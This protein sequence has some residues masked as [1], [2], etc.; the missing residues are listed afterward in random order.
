[1]RITD[2][3]GGEKQLVWDEKG[4]LVQHTDCSGKSTSYTWTPRGDLASIR[5]MQGE[6]TSFVYNSLHELQAIHHPDATQETFRYYPSGQL[7]Y[8]QNAAGQRREWRY[9]QRGQP[10]Q[11]V[12]RLSR[13]IQY[14]Y[15]ARGNLSRLLN[16]NGGEYRFRYDVSDRL[17]E[18]WRPDST[19]RRIEYDAA[20]RPASLEWLG[21]DYA[22][23]PTQRRTKT[24]EYDRGDRPLSCHTEMTTRFYTHDAAG[25]L[26]QLERRPTAAGEAQGIQHGVLQLKR[27]KNGRVLE[28]VLDG[29]TT[30]YRWGLLGE[31][32]ALTLPDNTTL[33]W[34][35]YGS[36]H[37]SAI[38]CDNEVVTEF[39]RDDLHREIRRSQGA[40]TQW[41]GYDARGRRHWQSACAGDMPDM[42]AARAQQGK[43]WRRF[44][45]DLAGEL[46]KTE[47]PFRGVQRYRY[48][49]ESRLLGYELPGPEGGEERFSY[50]RADNIF[51]L[52]EVEWDTHHNGRPE[53]FRSNRLPFWKGTGYRYDGFGNLTERTEGSGTQ[54]FRYDDENRLIKAWGEGPEG[55][56]RAEYRYDVL[57]R[58]TSKR[59]VYGDSAEAEETYFRWEGLRLV[60]ER[61]GGT[62]RSYV[63]D[64]D[65][66]Y[67]P[68]ARITREGGERETA[69]FHT[70]LNGTPLE[71]TD[72]EG[73]IRW[74][75][76]SRAWGRVIPH[77]RLEKECGG[78]AVQPLRYPGQYSDEETGLHYNTL[79]YYDPEVGR[80]TTQDP[81]GLAG[82]LNLYQYAPNSL[83]WIDPLGLKCT[84]SAKNPK[85]FHAAV[86]DKWGHKMTPTDMR[87]V[88]KTI[89]RIK[90]NNLFYSNDGTIFGNTHTIGNSNSQRL[91]T[92]SGPYRE[93]TVK[94]PNTGGN[95]ARRIVVDSATG[96]AYY[97]HDH[98]DS[99]IEISLGGWK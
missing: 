42:T 51:A 57:G 6:V 16:A 24:Y 79:R 58:R 92:G 62:T 59:V 95:G 60:Q 8:H 20:G 73:H 84:H 76:K 30:Q 26:V 56:Y 80:F 37:V 19:R 1:M 18:E 75:G 97:T 69:Y 93:W 48:D 68:L 61:R 50:D 13:T 63:Y 5:N 86:S 9:N 87:E 71:V 33:Q 81:I 82:G 53:G 2:A 10:L 3:G 46:V 45:F 72:G 40:L 31:L 49:A 36:G 74:C 94:T 41:R 91:N 83:S 85:E 98:Y 47:D 39:E 43:V 17:A 12:D 29:E 99:F 96:K 55:R 78:L 66:H 15:D 90:S 52:P 23:N 44:H 27:D 25:R 64:P 21:S 88:Q 67:T 70:D 38:R 28:E 11:S 77:V 14:D 22:H 32:T 4:Q 34:L 7:R 35:H 89:D 65:E 54:Q